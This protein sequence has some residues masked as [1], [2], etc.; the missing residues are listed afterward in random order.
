[1]ID[2]LVMSAHLLLAMSAII[3]ELL[4]IVWLIT[5]S[6]QSVSAQHVYGGNKL[7]DCKDNSAESSGYVC[8]GAEKS[9]DTYAL[10]HAQPPYQ[11]LFSIS[12]LFNVGI[13]EL[14]SASNL[15]PRD[16]ILER[17]QGVFIP[18]KCGCMGNHYQASL[19][20]SISNGD[21]YFS[22]TKALE[23]LTSCEALQK[24]NLAR[25]FRVGGNMLIP[26]RCACPTAEQIRQGFNYLMTYAVKNGDTL[27]TV[28]EAFNTSGY[29]IVF[30]NTLQGV[31]TTFFSSGSILVP[32]KNKPVIHHTLQVPA[33]ATPPPSDPGVHNIS[34][35]IITA[36]RKKKKSKCGLYIGIVTGILAVTGAIGIVLLVTRRRNKSLEKPA[37]SSSIQEACHTQV[38]RWECLREKC[39]QGA[40]DRHDRSANAY[41]HI[42]SVE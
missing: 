17:D 38:R 28:A 16:T 42:G 39:F 12:K 5:L 11:S 4:F 18:L 32:L 40:N 7:F 33:G 22:L 6:L 9:C 2:P 24:Q 37:A 26:L 30:A 35:N 8:N 34:S 29:D 23:G 27:D 1:L 13:S 31:Q 21:S 25:S 10:F 3:F 20:Y 19:R 41:L 36:R 15:P 14:A